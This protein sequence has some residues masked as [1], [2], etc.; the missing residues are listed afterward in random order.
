MYLVVQSLDVF[1]DGI[2]ELRLV[3]LYSA[4]DL[5]AHEQRVELAEDAEHL[6]RVTRRA[7]TVAQARDDLVLDA[8]HALVVCVLCRDP[9][10]RAIYPRESVCHVKRRRGKGRTG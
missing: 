7:Q 5:R 9:D 3:L 2:D 8:R 4:T 6:V 10:L 1:L